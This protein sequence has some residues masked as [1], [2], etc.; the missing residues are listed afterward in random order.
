MKSGIHLTSDDRNAIVELMHEFYWL[1]DQGNAVKTA[2]LFSP[3]ARLVFGPTTPHPGT[4]TGKDI[5]SF[6]ATREKQLHVTTRHVLSNIRL[7]ALSKKSV[8]G[9]SLLTL[10]RS[11]TPVLE[12][13]PAS[14]ADVN[15]VF[16]WT[17][18]GWLI[19][20]REINLI[21]SRGEI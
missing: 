2:P 21:F 19:Q 16:V 1:I 7:T 10:F 4:V 11:D 13:Y 14:V 9:Y 8:A 6:L 18:A 5:P 12:S 20:D 17:E 15:E 3:D